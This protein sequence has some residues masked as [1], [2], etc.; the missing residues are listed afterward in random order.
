MAGFW[1]AGMVDTGLISNQYSQF[2][3]KREKSA[4]DQGFQYP[5]MS[6]FGIV[7]RVDPYAPIK[8]RKKDDGTAEDGAAVVG[9]SASATGEKRK[10]EGDGGSVGKK[11]KKIDVVIL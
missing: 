9:D 5:E 11:S 4:D 10:S 6:P 2:K 1:P 3:K 8:V 7:I